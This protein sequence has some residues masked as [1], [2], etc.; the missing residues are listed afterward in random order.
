MIH[1]YLTKAQTVL[2]SLKSVE[3]TNLFFYLERQSSLKVVLG[4]KLKVL[5]RGTSY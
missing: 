4:H 1:G 5:G 2:Q 3:Q